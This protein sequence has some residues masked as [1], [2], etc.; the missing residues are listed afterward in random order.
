MNWSRG[1]YSVGNATLNRFFSPHYLPPFAIAGATLAHIA[2]IH[3]DGSNNP[4]G[5]NGNIDKIP[6][7]PYSYT[8]DSYSTILFTIFLSLFVSSAPNILNHPD[9]HTDA[10][11]PVTPP[12]I[13]PE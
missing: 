2:H 10:N 1:A 5:I 8:K 11:P 9:N 7:Y 6:S 12:H 13:V 3:K 4:L